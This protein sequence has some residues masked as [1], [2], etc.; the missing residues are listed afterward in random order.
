MSIQTVNNGKLLVME[1][2]TIEMVRQICPDLSLALKTR[3]SVC[4]T[5]SSVG[6]ESEEAVEVL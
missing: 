2:N 5:G 4:D 1:W 3:L 6:E